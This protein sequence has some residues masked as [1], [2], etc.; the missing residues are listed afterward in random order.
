ML[1]AKCLMITESFP[2]VVQVDIR[3]RN[4]FKMISAMQLDKSPT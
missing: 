3:Q 4:E 2:T 1:S